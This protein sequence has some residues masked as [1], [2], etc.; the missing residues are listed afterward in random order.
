[1]AQKLLRGFM[2]KNS[3]Q[4]IKQFRIEKVITKCEK[5]YVKQKV[6]DHLMAGL[7]KRVCTK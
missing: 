7:I 3:K 1:M 4:Q 5:V 6:Y 2:K